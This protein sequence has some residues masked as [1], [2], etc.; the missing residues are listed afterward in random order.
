ME[1]LKCHKEN[2]LYHD[3]ESHK[4]VSETMAKY[5]GIEM[6][7]QPEDKGCG[8]IF[9]IWIFI[10][11]LGYIA[12]YVTSIREEHPVISLIVALFVAI[13]AVFGKG[14]ICILFLNFTKE[15]ENKRNEKYRRRHGVTCPY[16]KSVDTYKISNS[17]K[18]SL[19]QIFSYY[20]IYLYLI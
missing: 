9:A 16:C 6:K 7:K 11:V 2:K 5:A 20:I 15:Q 1:I 4:R 3:I 17:L 18:L 13:L 14:L 10:I 12:F 19:A 8:T